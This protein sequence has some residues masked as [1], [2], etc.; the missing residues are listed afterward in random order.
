MSSQIYCVDIKLHKQIHAQG[1]G[2]TKFYIAY[3]YAADRAE[4]EAVVTKWAVGREMEVKS[5]SASPAV[6]QDV[7]TY[8]FPHQIIN[9]PVDVLS[10]EYER[11]NY[12]ES[13]RAAGVKISI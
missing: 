2:F 3:A 6:N 13:Y 1:W 4:A 9:L 10:Q 8:A 11:R 7:R 5:T 12:P